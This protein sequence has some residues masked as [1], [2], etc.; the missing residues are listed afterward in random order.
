TGPRLVSPVV[1]DVLPPHEPPPERTR[2]RRRSEP[3]AVLTWKI[4]S[5]NLEAWI[6][7]RG[8]GWIAVMLLLF[9]TA[10]FLKYAFDNRWIGELGRVTIGI[11]AGALLSVAGLFFH[12][13]GWRLFSQMLSA[14]GVVLLYLATFGAFG[15]YHLIP[16]DRAAVFLVAIVVETAALAVL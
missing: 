10:F 12:R 14:G 9:D 5:A 7:G 4:D 15:Y 3:P 11:L 6:G 13:R 16:Q 2:I 8:L 1:P